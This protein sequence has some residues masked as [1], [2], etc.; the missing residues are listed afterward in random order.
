[1]AKQFAKMPHSISEK[2]SGAPA[3]MEISGKTLAIIGLGSSGEEL[4]IRAK[5]LGMRVLATKGNPDVKPSVEVD[6]LGGPGNMLE[7]LSEADFVVVLATLTE[8][9]IGLIGAAELDAMMPSAYLIN[10]ARGPL[11]DYESLLEALTDKKIA[12]AAFDV[13]WAEPAPPA[14]P[15]LK[16]DNFFMSPHVA[17]FSDNS[18]EHVTKIMAENFRRLASEQP[19]VNVVDP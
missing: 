2:I 4:A 19:L 17:G 9:T 5:A 11:V 18:I 10:V 8:T 3:G 6:V 13:F 16:L 1:M 7:F 15:M 12:G 14:D